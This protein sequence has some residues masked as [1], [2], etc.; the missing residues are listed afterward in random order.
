MMRL[1]AVAGIAIGA[2]RL[3][4]RTTADQKQ[5]RM[6]KQEVKEEAQADARATRT[7][8]RQDPVPAAAHDPQPD[9]GRRSPG[10]TSWS[11]TRRTSPSR[12]ATSRSESRAACRGQGS[13]RGRR[14][15]PRARRTEH[16]VPMVEDV[17][18]ARALHALVQDRPGDPGRAV[19]AVARVLAFVMSLK[20]PVHRPAC[21]ATLHVST[22]ASARL[23]LRQGIRPKLP[24]GP[25]R[26]ER[27]AGTRRACS[28]DGD[29]GHGSGTSCEGVRSVPTRRLSHL[30]V[31]VGVVAIVVMLVVPLP[32]VRARHADR[33]QHHAGRPGAAASAMLGQAAARLLGLPLAAAGRHPVPARRSTSPRPGSSSATATPARSSR[34][35]ATSSSAARS[36]SAWSS[37]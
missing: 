34:R 28:H 5:I 27:A 32:A 21:T 13:G 20:R 16:R 8:A 1:C 4:G 10:P 17:P 18:L 3:R 11:S 22:A 26:R 9:D 19:Q 7:C 30:A 35:S 33:L 15:D 36:S 31:P 14:A 12:C 23:D 25:G 37:S 24:M 2:G 6:S 29:R